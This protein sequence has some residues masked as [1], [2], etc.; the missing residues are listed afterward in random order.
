MTFY[1]NFLKTFDKSAISIKQIKVCIS[2]KYFNYASQEFSHFTFGELENVK[3]KK[4]LI[5][6]NSL[7]TSLCIN[8][9]TC[10]V[11]YLVKLWKFQIRLKCPRNSLVLPLDGLKMFT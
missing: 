7:N 5:N 3:L 4:K 10:L 9:L 1:R 11:N 8:N 2:F 6:T